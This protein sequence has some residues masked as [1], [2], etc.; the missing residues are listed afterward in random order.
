M[1][2]ETREIIKK[3]YVNSYVAIVGSRFNSEVECKKYE[4]SASMVAYSKYK[5]FISVRK[6]QYEIYGAGS[7]E[8]EIDIVKINCYED[9]DTILHM[10][11]LYHPSYNKDTI[12]QER[13]RL[14][15]WFS[16]GEIVFIGRGCGYDNYDSFEFIGTMN[17]VI[18][19]I[20]KACNENE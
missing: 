10:Y 2:I 3:E 5:P 6:S 4:E 16:D 8:Y 19:H 20:K 7:D 14:N 12:A 17:D 9:I 13:I 15:K 11:S 1:Q 18:N